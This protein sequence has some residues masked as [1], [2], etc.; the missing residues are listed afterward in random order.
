M[1]YC[2][3]FLAALAVLLPQAAISG[4]VAAAWFTNSAI[5]NKDTFGEGKKVPNG[6]IGD[7][8]HPA[9]AYVFDLA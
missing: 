8:I 7:C 1:K 5:P 6:T 4:K 3:L 9:S 2:V